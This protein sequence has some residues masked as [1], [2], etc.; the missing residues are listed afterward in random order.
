MPG[1]DLVAPADD[2]PAEL[3]DLRWARVVLEVGTEPSDELQGEGRVVVVIDR[4][5]NLFGVPRSAD[6]AARVTASSSPSSLVRPRLSSRT[7]GMVS[8]RR[9][10]YSGS[11]L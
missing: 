10:R 7:S 3:A 1:G 11:S 2:N 6:L 9:L 8:N 5:D 4:S